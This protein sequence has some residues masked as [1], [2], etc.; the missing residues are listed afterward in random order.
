MK[1]Q[2]GRGGGGVDRFDGIDEFDGIDR[3]KGG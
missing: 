3:R 2:E 1:R